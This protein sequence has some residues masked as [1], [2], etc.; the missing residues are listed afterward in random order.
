MPH[1]DPFTEDHKF[2]FDDVLDV[3]E[4]Q[5]DQTAHGAHQEEEVERLASASAIAE[6]AKNYNYWVYGELGPGAIGLLKK[7]QQQRFEER[8]FMEETVGE[9]EEVD[10]DGGEEEN[11]EVA[12]GSCMG[13]KEKWIRLLSFTQA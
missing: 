4:E 1:E 5:V 12:L 10:E 13:W 9:E 8:R 7:T 2:N 11:E 3:H 6:A